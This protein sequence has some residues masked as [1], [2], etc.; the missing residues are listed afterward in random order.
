MHFHNPL[1]LPGN[2]IITSKVVFRG[3]RN[4]SVIKRVS[5]SCRELELSSK[6]HNDQL[7][8]LQYPLPY[9]AYTKVYKQLKKSEAVFKK[10]EKSWVWIIPVILALRKQKQEDT[11][12]NLKACLGCIVNSR[13]DLKRKGTEKTTQSVYAY[14]Q[15]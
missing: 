3:Y 2:Q 7:Q 14:L 5:C 8:R 9:I 15:A 11:T 6:N 10:R 12:I 4:S 13:S 1:K